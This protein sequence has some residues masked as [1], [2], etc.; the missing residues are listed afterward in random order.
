VLQTRKV[1][2][3]FVYDI[4][5]WL[6]ENT[7]QDEAGT[8]AYKT[9]ELDTFF[10]DKPV[11]Y[12]EVQG[13]ESERFVALFPHGIRILSGGVESGFHHVKPEEYKPRLMQ[14]KGKGRDIRLSEV[15]LSRD[16][17]NSGDVFILDAGLKVYQWNGS[18][19]S[20]MERNKASNLCRAIDDE[21]GSKVEIIVMEDG[22]DRNQN[23]FWA[24]LGGYGPVKSAEAGGADVHA[25]DTKKLFKLSDAGGTLSFTEVASGR[26]TRNLLN[27]ND[28]FVFDIGSQII[29]WIG[30]HASAQERAK[31]LAIAQDYITKQNRPPFTTLCRVLEGGEN[32]VFEAAFDK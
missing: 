30:L 21:R 23:D 1:E 29:V 2:D 13:Y 14:A 26:V 9:V 25:H 3:K 10:K 5:F 28:A 17:L 4:F 24:H 22:S 32:E 11:E 7:T 12:R 8:A 19:S 27:S 15:P 16:S 6:G 20:G 31:G 18:K